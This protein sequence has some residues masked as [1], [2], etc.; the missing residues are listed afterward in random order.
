M[1]RKRDLPTQPARAAS[2]LCCGAF[3]FVAAS[4]G[5]EE[6][7]LLREARGA[8]AE[9][10][11]EVAIAKIELLQARADFPDEHRAAAA[12]LLGE[13]QLAAGQH[14]RALRSIQPLVVAEIP[15]AQVLQAHIFVSAGRWREAL[16]IYQKLAAAPVALPA[17]RLG[18]AESLHATGD[19][20]GA[21]AV[22]EDF[23]S[24][25]PENTAARLRL[26]GLLSA[27]KQSVRARAVLT[28]T[29]RKLPGEQLWAR[30]LE[31]RVLLLENHAEEAASIFEEVIAA[32]AHLSQDLL[33]AATLALT[34]ARDTLGGPEVADRVLES[35]IRQ[36]PESRHLEVMFR[37]LDQIHAAQKSPQ[38]GEL[39]KWAAAPEMP[40]AALA[41]FYV[42]RMQLRAEKLDR[43]TISVDAFLRRFPE[44]PLLPQV[45]MMQA[46]IDLKH[47]L[48]P[49]AVVALESAERHA[50]TEEVR[51]EIELR[52]GLVHYWQ[53]EFLLA[54]NKFESAA[55]RA[56]ELRQAATF[57]AALA[58]LQQK[59]FDRFYEQYRELNARYPESDLRA[60]LILEEGLLQAR[61]GDPRSEETLQLFLLQFPRHSRQPEARLALAE[62]AF[63]TGDSAAAGRYLQVANQSSET[64]ETDAHT[65]YLAIFLE[66]AKQ[67][68]HDARVIELAR[69]F[70]SKYPASPLLPE[71]RFK[72]GQVYFRTD[73]FPNAETQFA[74]LAQDFPTSPYAE[75]AL[76]LAGQ[77][78][79][80]MI[81][82]GAIDRALALFDQ[83]VKRDGPLELYARQQQALVQ[84]GLGREAEAIQI[85]DIILT[86]QPPADPELRYAALCEKGDSLAT[87]GRKDPTMIPAALAVFAELAAPE[88]PAVWRNQALYKS[89]KVLE[90]QGRTPE[91]LN[92]Y[93][94][95]LAKRALE[96]R[97]FVWFYKAG[98][99][100][101]RIFET[102][103][104]WKSA[105]GIYEKMAA[106]EGPRAAEAERRVKDL[107]LEH[108]LWD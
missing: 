5:A 44:H 35:F 47:G 25:F 92:A 28:A 105:I 1:K 49:N 42:T 63:T 95:V 27:L 74:T 83:V 94:D 72:L 66:A 6:P 104:N 20:K 107:R 64:P 90:Q 67:P 46:E 31:G 99:E 40:R 103:K 22:L 75:T 38:E 21:V 55:R 39:Q 97:E 34:N 106:F 98:F 23:V 86:A 60:E 101:A 19:T 85:Y 78:A 41:R 26:T 36:N 80:K 15:A 93:Y 58:T 37:R 4:C 16:P 84:S 17:A 79:R 62:L 53:G 70:I 96:D 73:D 2:W 14:E 89:G 76:F 61:T 69:L 77:A 50:R 30:Y 54:A 65:A 51:A 10:I 56:P 91:A 8:L 48:F 59:N 102:E 29:V 43:A 9:A 11:P 100:A 13:A 18:M 33:A 88:I 52:T 7:A 108:F 82:P 12:M 57:N 68:P 71:V 45:H 24:E 81:N 3:L 87:L 32:P